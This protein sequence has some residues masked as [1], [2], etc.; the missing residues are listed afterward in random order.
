MSASLR[1]TSVLTVLTALLTPLWGRAQSAD[2][3]VVL[4][5]NGVK[6][7]LEALQSDAQRAVKH[8]L[9]MEFGTAAALRQ[10][11]EGG[12]PFDA[13]VLT[14]EAF[15]D[16]AAK[17]FVVPGTRAALGKAGIGVG[18]RLAP[19]KPDISTPEA[20]KRALVTA[21]AI[22]YAGDGASRR[23]IEAMIATL[24]VTDVVQPKTVLEQGS[25]RSAARVLNG[26]ADLLFTLTS[27]ILPIKGLMLVGPLP[28]RFQSYIS[29]AGG[30]SARARQAEAG[31]ALME[32]LAA[33]AAMHT[34]REKGIER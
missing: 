33:P 1:L 3:L 5:T 8:P 26:D 31:R 27:E 7:T 4:A 17:G 29:F 6:S 24:G 19:S 22:T 30:V 9:A 21:K 14:V 2:V 10:K 11:I 12:A 32:F 23:S 28:E 20:M 13:A 25:L 16:L 18:A 34:F 15:D